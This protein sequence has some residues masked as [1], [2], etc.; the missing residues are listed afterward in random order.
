MR[1]KAVREW[2]APHLQPRNLYWRTDFHP[3][4]LPIL[5]PLRHA[6]P[7][8]ECRFSGLVESRCDAVALGNPEVAFRGRQDRF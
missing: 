7:F 1:E 5:A 2:L 6:D 3:P 4:P 8:D